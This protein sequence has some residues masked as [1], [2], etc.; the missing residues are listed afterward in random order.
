MSNKNDFKAFSIGNNANVV[1]QERYEESQNLKTGFPP[2]GITTHELNKALRQSSTIASVVA[3]FMST[4]C[5]RDVLDNGDL[6]TLNKTF[7]DSL[8]CHVNKKFPGSLSPNGYQQLP[9]GLILQWGRHNFTPLKLNKVILP[10]AFK[11]KFLHVFMTPIGDWIFP[12][13]ASAHPDSLDSFNSWVAAR[14][15]NAY[16]SAIRLSAN[17]TYVYGDY[18]AIG[19]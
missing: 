12:M 8:E 2:E 13:S 14:T 9:G 17:D 3:N 16:G 19:Y 5:G 7:T 1:S 15:I 11:H 4:Q 10:T 18:F 6:A